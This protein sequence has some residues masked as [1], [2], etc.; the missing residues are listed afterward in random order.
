MLYTIH[1]LVWLIITLTMTAIDERSALDVRCSGTEKVVTE[2]NN[3]KRY[4][5]A[6]PFI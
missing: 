6:M 5:S 2:V 1:Y 3:S 4:S